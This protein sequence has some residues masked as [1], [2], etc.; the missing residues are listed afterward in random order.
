MI[1]GGHHLTKTLQQLFVTH[2]LTKF[3]Y[4]LVFFLLINSLN[5]LTCSS[6]PET[7]PSS[8]TPCRKKASLSLDL[9]ADK[10][11]KVTASPR[12]VELSLKM[13]TFF[14]LLF[15]AD[16]STYEARTRMSKKSEKRLVWRRMMLDWVDGSLI[17]R[18]WRQQKL[19]SIGDIL[20]GVISST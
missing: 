12:P 15:L 8:G 2:L 3:S 13:G 11:G 14:F 16:A 9:K 19:L 7:W 5:F 18:E 4:F 10:K 6:L 17:K 1:K 20:T